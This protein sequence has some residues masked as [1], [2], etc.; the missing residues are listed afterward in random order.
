MLNV[1]LL[2]R[3]SLIKLIRIPQPGLVDNPKLYVVHSTKPEADVEG[4]IYSELYMTDKK[5]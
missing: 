3:T 4:N 5:Y 2:S 1:M